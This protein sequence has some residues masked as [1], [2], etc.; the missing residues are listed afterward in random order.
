MALYANVCLGMCFKYYYMVASDVSDDHLV[1]EK[2]FLGV[3]V[4]GPWRFLC[5]KDK[6]DSDMVCHACVS[7]WVLEFY[8]STI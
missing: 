2:Q 1:V 5:S 6:F 8:F 7:L 3:D 4:T